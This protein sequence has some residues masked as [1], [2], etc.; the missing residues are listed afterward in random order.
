MDE[1][2]NNTSI[3][4]TKYDQSHQYDLGN[5]LKQKDLSKKKKIMNTISGVG[6][7]CVGPI[8]STT[9]IVWNIVSERKIPSHY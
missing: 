7:F 3:N 8:F 2:R 4:V 9:G 5:K 6:I 1:V